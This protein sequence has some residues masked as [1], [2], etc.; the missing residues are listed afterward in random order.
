MVEKQWSAPHATT[1]TGFEGAGEGCERC[2]GPGNRLFEEVESEISEGKERDHIEGYRA[3]PVVVHSCAAYVYCKIHKP[4]G[5]KFIF[6]V[7]LRLRAHRPPASIA[8]GDGE[9]FGYPDHTEGDLG[10]CTLPGGLG[11]GFITLNGSSD[12]TESVWP[13]LWDH[14]RGNRSWQRIRRV[15]GRRPSRLPAG[16]SVH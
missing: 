11:P 16:V 12:A 4:L 15:V 13:E 8:E 6:L 14:K 5:P 7:V 3:E 2:E 9:T 10:S 1:K